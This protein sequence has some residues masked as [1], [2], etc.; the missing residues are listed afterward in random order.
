MLSHFSC[1]QLC[2]TLQTTACQSP[3]STSF[4]RQEYWSGLS[5]CTPRDLPD[6]GIKRESPALQAD[7]L[8]LSHRRSPFYQSAYSNTASPVYLSQNSSKQ[9]EAP[10]YYHFLGIQPPWYQSSKL[11]LGSSCLENPMD[12]GAW[13][14]AVHGVA[15]SRA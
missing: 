7:S 15:K 6:P 11:D 2:E 9:L 8:P 12:R 10:R 14:A 5:C 3:L 13:K 4:S 1:V